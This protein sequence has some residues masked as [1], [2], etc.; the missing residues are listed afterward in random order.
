MLHI[1]LLILKFIGIIIAAILGILVLLICIVL[2]AA[3][4]Y[5]A[6]AACGEGFDSLRGK[7]RVTW[8]F[9]LLRADVYYKEGKLKWRLRFA[10]FKRCSG[11]RPDEEKKTETIKKSD[12]KEE[13]GD[14]NEKKQKSN[15]EKLEESEEKL[16]E[17]AK[18]APLEERAEEDKGMEDAQGSP[19]QPQE[20][21]QAYEK[22]CEETPEA[23]EGPGQGEDHTE[24]KGNHILQKVKA[25]WEKIKC[26]F[27]KFCDR[28]KLL[29][30]KKDR[31]AGFVQDEV[32]RRA[33]SKT[34]KE[35]FWFLGKLKPGEVDMKIRYGFEDP[36]HTGQVL[37]GVSMLYPFLGDGTEIIPDFEHKVFKGNLR[38]KGRIRLGHLACLLWKLFWNRDVRQSYRDI[39]NFRL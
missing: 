33:F 23:D 7:A 35:I 10:F 37:A 3:V 2:F 22:T 36:C 21:E 28:I 9:H 15:D 27:E 8:L 11:S 31:L 14:Q 32:H 26:T 34:K 24:R 5:E 1:L 25:V 13:E 12:T 30:E 39:K 18:E 29:K 4:R 16:E 17:T 38:A 19:E 20:V 6:Q